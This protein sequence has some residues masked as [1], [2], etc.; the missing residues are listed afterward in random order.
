MTDKKQNIGESWLL[1][2]LIYCH[3]T[4]ASWPES[5][6]IA[7]GISKED[8]KKAVKANK[9]DEAELRARGEKI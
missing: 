8:W 3:R 2:Q 6:R 4:V 7:A 1:R 9:E 5:K